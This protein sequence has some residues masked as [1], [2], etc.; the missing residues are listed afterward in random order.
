MR[1]PGEDE[2]GA[3]DVG[4]EVAGFW[5]ALVRGETHVAQDVAR[6]LVGHVPLVSATFSFEE[7]SGEG[8]AGEQGVAAAVAPD[9]PGPTIELWNADAEVPF[10]VVSAERHCLGRL[11]VSGATKDFQACLKPGPQGGSEACTILRHTDPKMRYGLAVAPTL[12]YVGIRTRPTGQTR[13]PSLFS[14]PLV[15]LSEAPGELLEDGFLDRLLE[16]AAAPRVAR[17]LLESWPEKA[18]LIFWRG[19]ADSAEEILRSPRA[20]SATGVAGGAGAGEELEELGDGGR[21]P[22]GPSTPRPR[23]EARPGEG[24]GAGSSEGGAGS[25]QGTGGDRAGGA[26][27]ASPWLKF[28]SAGGDGGSGSG[29]DGSSSPSSDDDSLPGSGSEGGRAPRSRDDLEGEVALLTEKLAS[30]EGKLEELTLAEEERRKANDEAL[31]SVFEAFDG[32]VKA[33]ERGQGGGPSSLSSRDRRRVA[34][35]VLASIDLDDYA[36]K[37]QLS[38][39]VPRRELNNPP[40]GTA[41]HHLLGMRSKVGALETAVSA[42][43]GDFKTLEGRVDTLEKK[44]HAD[45]VEFGG[46]VF[47]DAQSTSAWFQLLGDPEA[48]RFCPD[49]VT[50]LSIT[51]ESVTTIADGL[52]ANADA[53]RAGFTTV[54]GAEATITYQIPYPENI[55]TSSKGSGSLTEMGGYAWAP[56]WESREAFV[57]LFNNGTKSWFKT[58]VQ[59]GIKNFQAAID[60]Q[61]PRT[62]RAQVN[63]VFTEVVRQAGAQALMFLDSIEP[64]ADMLET[65]G[66]SAQDAWNRA[67]LYPKT[68][69]DSIRAVRVTAP[70]GMPG[71]A[72]LWGSFQATKLVQEFAR[73][74]FTDHPR[75]STLLA[76]TSMQKEGVAIKKL[77]KDL[78]RETGKVI[79]LEKKVGGLERRLG[80]LERKS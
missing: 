17:L 49:F 8:G 78:S 69:F 61:Y 32:R 29:G 4:A 9:T 70:K 47:K 67:A 13:D 62:G 3:P 15:P 6:R 55:L 41:L 7:E 14:R 72:M 66:M 75:I 77:E 36:T 31:L 12:E 38:G 2:G 23:G 54:T 34:S 40:P 59:G 39:L 1:G 25:G 56:G 27:G 20:G 42:P 73:H 71:G 22:P 10:V 37:D 48:H 68:L 33:L 65:T 43:T 74:G 50:I 51:N 21:E 44:R 5:R 64:L 53:I 57:G 11:G 60:M 63:E 24:R 18:R 30:V 28:R 52:K 80:E 58:S 46:V 19:G 76:I 26:Q 35:A 79:A 45:A 16:V